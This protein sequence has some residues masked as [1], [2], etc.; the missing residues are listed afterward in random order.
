[1]NNIRRFET[2]EAMEI[3]HHDDVNNFP[4]VWM[5]GQ[6]TDEEILEC[7]SKI[8]AK[9]LDDCV[10]IGAGGLILKADKQKYL[11]MFKRHDEERKI[12][13]ES[14]KNLYEMILHEMY[15]YEYGYTCDPH[16]TLLAL[17]KTEKDLETDEKF[18][19]AWNKAKKIVLDDCDD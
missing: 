16:D 14:E 10:G 12:F 5:F 6:K 13:S 7:I 19:R 2:Y 3:T 1:M 17:G 8:G 9:S 11:D 4:M 15:N 18:R